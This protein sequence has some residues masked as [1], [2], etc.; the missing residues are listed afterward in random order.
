MYE[1]QKV[2][3]KL[4]TQYV[5]LDPYIYCFGQSFHPVRSLGTLEYLEKISDMDE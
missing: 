5:Y 4:L 2:I 3:A 1:G